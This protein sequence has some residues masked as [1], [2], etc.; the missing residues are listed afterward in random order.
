[1]VRIV[2]RTEAHYKAK[3]MEFGKVR[4]W[5]PERLVLECRCGERPTLTSTVTACDGCGK[6]YMLVFRVESASRPF[7][8]EADMGNGS[9]PL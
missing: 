8:G 9:S 6:D 7:G 1:M 3:E 5:Y 4:R 2:E